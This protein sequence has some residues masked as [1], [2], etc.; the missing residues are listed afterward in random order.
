[1]FLDWCFRSGIDWWEVYRGIP[2][3]PSGVFMSSW[4]KMPFYSIDF[5][6]GR[7]VFAGPAVTPL[8]EFVV[9]LPSPKEDGGLNVIIALQPDVM[10]KFEE[11]AKV[12]A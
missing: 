6:W 3:I 12:S 1:M 9:F 5:G 7:P 10:A 8:V 11:Y 4:Q 2:A